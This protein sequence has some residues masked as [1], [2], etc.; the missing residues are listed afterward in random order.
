MAAEIVT[1]RLGEWA[2]ARQTRIDEE[3][4]AEQWPPDVRARADA[5]ADRLR[6]NGVLPP[7]LCFVEWADQ[8]SM[9]DLFTRWLTP[10]DGARPIILYGDRFE[11]YAYGLPDGGC[12]LH[13]RSAGPQQ[14]VECDRFVKRLG[15]A[16][17]CWRRIADQ[18]ALIVLREVVGGLVSDD[19]LS[20][21]LQTVPDW[22]SGE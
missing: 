21:S 16:V 15:E 14:F 8:W 6:A 12:L 10:R 9:G 2:A 20:A 11:L 22:L 3:W 4:S 13:L 18:A 7:V 19:E 5:F 1:H 17:R